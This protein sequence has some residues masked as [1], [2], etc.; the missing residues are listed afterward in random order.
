[1]KI[2]RGPPGFSAIFRSSESVCVPGRLKR[3][4]TSRAASAA[5]KPSSPDN[6]VLGSDSTDRSVDI[7]HIQA[8]DVRARQADARSPGQPA[9]SLVRAPPHGYHAM[10]RLLPQRRSW[11]VMA[12]EA[13][14]RFC[15]GKARDGIVSCDV[16]TERPPVRVSGLRSTTAFDTADPRRDRSR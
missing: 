13:P 9:S 6:G 11:P 7:T 16:R 14:Q 15:D 12:S 4:G 5:A 3:N 8:V 2:A 10:S 1:M